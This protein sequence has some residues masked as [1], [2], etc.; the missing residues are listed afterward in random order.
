VL[1]LIVVALLALGGAGY[2]LRRVLLS[3]DGAASE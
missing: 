2:A 1:A 3:R